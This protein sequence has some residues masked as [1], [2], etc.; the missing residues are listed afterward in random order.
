MRQIYPLIFFG[1]GGVL[2]ATYIIN[3]LPS[4][5]INNKTPY[6]ILL[7]CKPQYDHMRVFGCLVYAKENKVSKDKF[8]ERGIPCVFL[9]YQ[10]RQKCY[11]M[12][13]LKDKRIIVSRDVKFVKHHYP[14]K[15]ID[16]NP[17]RSETELEN[18]GL[19]PFL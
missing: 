6:E 9:G 14:F 1:E 15:T 2:T 7:N 11:R 17:H 3:R 16:K 4:K 5:V 10:Q 13:D 8:E 19:R 18:V 12:Y